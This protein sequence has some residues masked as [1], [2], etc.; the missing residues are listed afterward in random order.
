MDPMVLL[1]VVLLLAVAI[2]AFVMVTPGMREATAKGGHD[3]HHS[4]AAPAPK[5]EAEESPRVAAAAAPAVEAAP[6]ASA[7]AVEPE[8][9]EPVPDEDLVEVE[10]IPAVI[11]PEPIISGS[12]AATLDEPT[13]ATE[14]D[15]VA[16]VDEP[17]YEPDLPQL[18][19]AVADT[20]GT[21]T[22]AAVE[23]VEQ[24]WDGPF[25]P[26]SAD[27]NEDGSG[28]RGWEVKAAKQAK[29][30]LTPDLP[31]YDQAKANLWFVDEQ[32]AIDAGFVRWAP[33]A[34]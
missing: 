4:E 16:V 9:S 21:I 17:G 31:V 23:V 1:I 13:V 3:E 8:A 33:P 19:E 32:R 25:G 22:P 10:Q 30:Y 5:A 15:E 14:P 27:A 26:G 28:P 18:S 2:I 12:V 20:A 34:S 6:K 11:E 29:V 7:P 24:I